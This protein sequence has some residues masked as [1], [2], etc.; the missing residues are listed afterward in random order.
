MIDRLQAQSH[1]QVIPHLTLHR[2]FKTMTVKSC[3]SQMS[4]QLVCLC[5][6]LLMQQRQH[7]WETHSHLTTTATGDKDNH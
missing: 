3:L 5:M 1:L 2:G 6:L 7:A 4:S